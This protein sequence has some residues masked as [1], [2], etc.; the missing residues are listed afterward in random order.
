MSDQPTQEQT[1]E[2][3]NALTAGRKIE[4][5]K[6]YREA[7]GKGL[8]DAKDFVEALV[9]K[10]IEQDPEKYKALSVP[11]GAGCASALVACIGL[12]TVATLLVKAIT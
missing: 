4:A 2:I 12:G 10:L 1:Q 9:P 11:K 7:T 8:K 6:I 3:A 5:I